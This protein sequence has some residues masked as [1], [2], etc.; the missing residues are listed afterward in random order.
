MVM[1]EDDGAEQ[2]IRNKLAAWL[3]RE[4]NTDSPDA[5]GHDSSTEGTRVKTD[6]T[7]SGAVCHL[8]ANTCAEKGRPFNKERSRPEVQEKRTQLLT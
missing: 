3:K 6:R 7:A 8:R 5:G 2:R 4:L 1:C